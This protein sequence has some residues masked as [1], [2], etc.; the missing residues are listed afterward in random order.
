MAIGRYF[1]DFRV[2]ETFETEGITLTEG[3]IVDYGLVYDPQPFHVDS[4]A[5]N[6]SQFGGL[7]AS[8]FQVAALTC[9]LFRDTGLLQGT[10][11]GGTAADEIHWL[12]PVRPG[13]TIRARVEV[14]ELTPARARTD[15]GFVRFRYSTVNQHREV[16]MTMAIN[17][18]VAREAGDEV[19]V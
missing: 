4:E 2:G 19:D 13:D 6:R 7:V 11:M 16:V 14:I 15:R 5:A 3:Q 1:E 10:N 8:G 12:K 17:H 9:R 18:I